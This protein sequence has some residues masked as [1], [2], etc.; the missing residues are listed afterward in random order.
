VGRGDIT[1]TADL[2]RWVTVHLEPGARLFQEGIE[3]NIGVWHE[4]GHAEP[5]IIAM[6]FPPTPAAV[7]DDGLRWGIEPMFSDFKSRGFGLE[8]TQ[9][10]CPERVARLVLILTL[11]MYWCVETGCRDAYE[12]PIPLEKKPRSN[13][14]SS[15]GACANSPV[16]VYRG[17][18]ADKE[19]SCVWPSWGVRCPASVPRL[20]RSSAP[21]AEL[22]GGETQASPLPSLLFAIPSILYLPPFSRL[23]PSVHHTSKK[24]EAPAGKRLCPSWRPLRSHFV[25][26]EGSRTRPCCTRPYRTGSRCELRGPF[27]SHPSASPLLALFPP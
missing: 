14:T 5:W 18:S 25:G 1:Y 12:S 2:A 24:S 3:T 15:I 26:S 10:R 11:A 22:I 13:P 19:S 9:L 27:C 16:P 17:S 7:R 4:P 8:D 21:L 23:Q 20:L 6:E